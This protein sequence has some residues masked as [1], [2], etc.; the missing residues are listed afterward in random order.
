[1]YQRNYLTITI[2]PILKNKH[3]FLSLLLY[4][5]GGS[6]YYMGET[7]DGTQEITETRA[8][9]PDHTSREIDLSVNGIH[10]TPNKRTQNNKTK[11]TQ[12]NARE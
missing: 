10:E 7:N 3:H 9:K 4:A 12:D 1:M 6:D 8:L 11:K 5:I 2:S